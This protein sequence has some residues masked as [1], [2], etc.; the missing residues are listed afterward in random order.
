[1]NI[2]VFLTLAFVV[3]SAAAQ[4]QF[5]FPFI[6]KKQTGYIVI[7]SVD[8]GA[9]KLLK[10]LDANG[11][12]NLSPAEISNAPSTLRK[13]DRDRDG[14]LSPLEIKPTPSSETSQGFS[15]TMEFGLTR[16]NC[17]D[18]QEILGTQKIISQRITKGTASYANYAKDGLGIRR[19]AEVRII[20]TTTGLSKVL[21]LQMKA[22]RFL[23]KRDNDYFD[24]V[25]TIGPDVASRLFPGEN[26]IGKHLRM[27][28]DTSNFHFIIVGVLKDKNQG[29]M[30]VYIPQN[31]MKERIGDLE[32]NRS[33]GSY[34]AKKW[35]VNRAWVPVMNAK[36]A[37][38]MMTKVSNFLHLRDRPDLKVEFKP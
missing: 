19:K 13:L 15:F 24:S 9:E 1:M 33:A 5:R 18:L 14:T 7:D 17:D 34:R 11:D 29:N 3:S 4:A 38:P 22:G 30:S 23:E 27:T 12:G 36:Q 2:R 10:A 37:R 25:T 16:I 8:P 6:P 35:E 26:P 31:T 28:H 21:N 32:I 20:G